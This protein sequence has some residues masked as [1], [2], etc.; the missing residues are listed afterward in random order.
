MRE[1]PD[2]FYNQSAVI[3]YRQGEKGLEIMLIT[4]RKK[5][6]WVIPKGIAE[7]DMTPED[8]A[9][10]EAYEE[11]GIKGEVHSGVIGSY[12]YK[13]WGGTCTV[14]VYVMRVTEELQVW[15]EDFRDRSWLDLEEAA[16][17]MTEKA[18]RKIMRKTPDFLKDP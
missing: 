4:S 11:A 10:K 17:R 12:T 16:G 15:E 7:P 2:Y 18:M 3:P 13:K 8:S 5:K 14:K 6:R 9:A 1:H